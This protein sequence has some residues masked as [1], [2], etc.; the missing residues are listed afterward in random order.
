MGV[1]ANFDVLVKDQSGWSETTTVDNAHENS[2]AEMILSVREH[3]HWYTANVDDVVLLH[4]F[5]LDV[6]EQSDV[7]A[8]WLTTRHEFSF[9]IADVSYSTL[10]SP[11]EKEITPA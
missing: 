7:G 5:G 9:R 10:F 8:L 2:V 3:L 6:E 4:I 11:R 1:D